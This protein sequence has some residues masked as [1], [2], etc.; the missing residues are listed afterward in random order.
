M[1]HYLTIDVGGTYI[2]YALMNENAEILEK[3]EVPTPYDGLEPFIETIKKIYDQYADQNIE[4]IAMSAPGK[5]DANTGYFY[6]SGALNYINNV[7]LKDRLKEIIPVDFA[8]ENDAKAAAAAEIWK[9]SMKGIQNGTV[10]VLGTGIGGAIIID[11]KVYRG[12]TFAAGEYSGVPA[13]LYD[14]TYNAKNAWATING[15]GAMIHNYA[16]KLGVDPKEMNGKVLFTDAN[17]GKQ[18]AL[19]AINEY[20]TTLAS[21]II[22]LQFILDVQRVSIGG[23]ISK[24]PL[25]LE[26]LKK[27]LHEYYDNA[28]S[29]M[30]ATIPEV[31]TCEFGNDANMIG[32]LYHYLYVIKGEKL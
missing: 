23:G 1:S 28:S 31:V 24:Q 26:T 15:V 5:I 10:I 25:L 20:C 11:G 27:H 18:E 6:T 17:N 30:P 14:A 9:G 16:D 32:A 22:S 21:G 12:S 3:D 19:D 29:Y 7:N 13:S 8:V 2:K 4:A